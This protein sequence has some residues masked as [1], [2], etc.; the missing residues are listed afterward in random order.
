MGTAYI[1]GSKRETTRDIV[2][3]KN[4]VEA[5]KKLIHILAR[6]DFFRGA[7][8]TRP[9]RVVVV[10]LGQYHTAQVELELSFQRMINA[11]PVPVR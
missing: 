4:H 6:E 9:V 7:M 3:A 5:A 8:G 10:L 2:G 1:R 11:K